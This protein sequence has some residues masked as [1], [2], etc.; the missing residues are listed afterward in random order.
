MRKYP[1]IV[2]YLRR[3]DHLDHLDHVDVWRVL[4]VQHDIPDWMAQP[5]AEEGS[6]Q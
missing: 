6:V 3:L 1:F 5:D 4:H 2:F